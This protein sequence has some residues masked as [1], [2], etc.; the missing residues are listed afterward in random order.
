LALR[1]QTPASKLNELCN[2]IVRTIPS[3]SR[4]RTTHFD[5]SS[6]EN[7]VSKSSKPV[8]GRGGCANRL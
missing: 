3:V 2:E 4:A 8:K 6:A 7:K 5:T 1:N